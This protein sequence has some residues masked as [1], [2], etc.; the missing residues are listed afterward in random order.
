MSN[1]DLHF[2]AKEKS[3]QEVLV[4]ICIRWHCKK[5]D[6]AQHSLGSTKSCQKVMMHSSALHKLYCA[7]NLAFQLQIRYRWTNLGAAFWHPGVDA[8]IN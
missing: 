8:H 2:A 1:F 5:I 7:K 4:E 6:C 3:L